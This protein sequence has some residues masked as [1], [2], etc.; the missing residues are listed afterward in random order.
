MASWMSLGQNSVL[1]NFKKIL[2]AG[3]NEGGKK[4]QERGEY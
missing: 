1:N 4:K 3:D 2:Q